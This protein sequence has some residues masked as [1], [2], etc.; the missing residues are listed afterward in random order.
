MPGL[1][2]RTLWVKVDSLVLIHPGNELSC[3]VRSGNDSL[4]AVVSDFRIVVMP[5]L[6]L[7]GAH[8]RSICH[9]LT[10]VV[11]KVL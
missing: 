1:A 6:V 4:V 3:I 11:V 5:G 10:V 8:G 9:S 7:D 2:S